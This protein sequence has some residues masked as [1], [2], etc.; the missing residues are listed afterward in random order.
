MLVEGCPLISTHGL[1]ADSGLIGVEDAVGPVAE[2]VDGGNCGGEAE[3]VDVAHANDTVRRERPAL[4]AKLL[5]SATEGCFSSSSENWSAS[6][7]AS[8]RSSSSSGN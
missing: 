5:S 1:V 3:G 6:F 7:N 2:G 4:D 8:I